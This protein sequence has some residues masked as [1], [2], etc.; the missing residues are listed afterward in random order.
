VVFNSSGRIAVIASTA[1]GERA[2]ALRV[3]SG[4]RTPARRLFGTVWLA[5]T[6]RY[7]YGIRDGRITFVAAVSRADLR[8]AAT[9]RS[10]LRAAGLL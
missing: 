7:A 1:R 8:R 2:G 6:G 9:L 4:A 10:D 3:G 5:R